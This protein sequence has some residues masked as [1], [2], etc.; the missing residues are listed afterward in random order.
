M[1]SRCHTSEELVE[2]RAMV[3]LEQQIP[4]LYFK[5]HPDVRSPCCLTRTMP[6]LFNTRCVVGCALTSPRTATIIS[7]FFPARHLSRRKSKHHLELL[8][9]RDPPRPTSN[10][11]QSSDLFEPP[12]VGH[13]HFSRVPPCTRRRPIS[14]VLT[15]FNADHWCGPLGVMH[16]SRSAVG[17]VKAVIAAMMFISTAGSAIPVVE[18][19]E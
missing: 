13:L 3:V 6:Q 4:G 18:D 11:A 9:K 14:R 12:T 8:R 10:S 19:V 16:A 17:N 2:P 7:V 1:Q 15:T 5:L